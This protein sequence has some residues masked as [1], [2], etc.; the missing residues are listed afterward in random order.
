[1]GKSALALGTTFSRKQLHFLKGM[2]TLLKTTTPYTKLLFKT[3]HP[4]Y[5]ITLVAG[6]PKKTTTTTQQQQC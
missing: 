3:P 4:T 6:C 1:V 2:H 5:K